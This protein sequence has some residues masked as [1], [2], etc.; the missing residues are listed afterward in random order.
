MYSYVNKE[1][2]EELVEL[3]GPDG[4]VYFGSDSNGFYALRGTSPL[5]NSS[6]P[7]FHHDLRN[8]GRV[9]GR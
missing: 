4:T 9:G 5:A 8:T 7:K 6:W 1:R 3:L 2:C